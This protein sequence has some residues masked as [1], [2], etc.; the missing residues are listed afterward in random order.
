[1]SSEETESISDTS[2]DEPK[3]KEK[4]T[5]KDMIMMLTIEMT[6]KEQKKLLDKIEYMFPIK[7]KSLHDR[8]THRRL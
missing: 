3:F 6:K 4:Y 2:S 7:Y 5:T 1:M 8:L